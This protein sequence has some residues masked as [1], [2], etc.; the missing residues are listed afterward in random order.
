MEQDIYVF[1]SGQRGKRVDDI[2]G[3]GIYQ[4]CKNMRRVGR[5]SVFGLR[6][7]RWEVGKRLGPGSGGWCFVCVSCDS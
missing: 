4:S 2:I 7:C 1:G 6:W 3:F 5:V